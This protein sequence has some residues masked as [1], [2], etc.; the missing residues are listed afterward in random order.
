[1]T[2][3]SPSPEARELSLVGKVEMRI[4]LA[5][6]DLKLQTILGTFLPP[7][8]L[9]LASEHVAVRNKVISICQHINTRIKPESIKLPVAALMEQ[10]KANPHTP[11]IRHFDLIYIQNGIRRLSASESAVLFPSILQGIA[12]TFENSP[13]QGAQMFNF[14]LQVIAY[15]PLP[16]RGSEED[17][18]LR[19]SVKL[20][21]KDASFLASWFGKLILFSPVKGTNNSTLASG[22]A[23]PGLTPDEYAFFTLNK[24]DTW[25]PSSPQGLNLLEV[26]IRAAKLLASGLFNDSERFLPALFA[27]ADAA[28]SISDVGDDILKRARPN[29][30]LEDAELIG[31]LFRYYF[32]DEA[33][34][35]LVRVR[36]PLRLKILGLLEKSAISTT[37]SEEVTRVANDGITYAA[38]D[39]DSSIRPYYTSTVSVGREAT[40]LRTAVFQYINFAARHGDRKSLAIIAPR[41]VGRLR[42]YIEGQGWPR[43][44]NNEDLVSRG[45]AY[46]VIGLLAKAGPPGM[47]VEPNLDIL[48]WLFDSLAFETA[49]NSI[50]VS[51]E[52]ALSS[53]INIFSGG[54]DDKTA[55]SLELLLLDQMEQ[56]MALDQEQTQ[57]RRSTRYAAV[58]YANRCLSYQS[59]KA[60][61]IDLLAMAAGKD[62]RQ[63]VSEEGSKGL[64]P[65]WYRLLNGFNDRKPEDSEISFPAFTELVDYIFHQTSGSSAASRR[66]EPQAVVE[67]LRQKHPRVFPHALKY[68]RQVFLSEFVKIVP[69]VDWQLKFD[70]AIANDEGMRASIQGRIGELATDRSPQTAALELLL[71]A[72][73]THMMAQEEDKVIDTDI[74]N[75]FIELC[76]LSPDGLVGVV[77][78]MYGN[79]LPSIYSNKPAKRRAAAHAFGLLA[80][81]PVVQEQDRQTLSNVTDQLY[82]T[83]TTWQDAIGAALNRVH[84]A[85]TALSYYFSRIVGR[86]KES[87]SPILAKYIATITK[88]LS[89]TTD[90]FLKIASFVA[91]GELCMFQVVRPSDFG[92]GDELKVVIDGTAELAKS[93]NDGAALALGQIAMILDEPTPEASQ[94]GSLLLHV[95]DRL[96]R[97]HEVRQAEAQFSVGEAMTYMAAGWDSKVLATRK[98]VAGMTPK[99]RNRRGFLSRLVAKVLLDSQN[100][101]PSLRKASA[102]WLLCFVQFCGHLEEVQSQL[103]AFQTAFKRCLSDR[104]DLVQETG[105]RGLGLVYEKGDRRL[106]DDLVRDLIG[107][108]SDS[109]AQ[110]SGNVTSET[111]LFEPGALPTG[112]GSITTY[113]DI[114]NLASEVGDSTLVYKFMSLA[115]S[116]AIWSSRAAFGR[117]GLSDV[118]SDS[119]VDGY[120]ATNPK[121]YPKLFRYRFDPNTN[122]QRSMNDIWNALIKDTTATIDANFD[123][124]VEDLLHNILGKEWRV[125]QACCAALAD[126]ISSRPFDKYEKYLEQV[127]T[128]C[129][130]V[131]DDIKDSVRKAAASLARVMT[132]VL[133]RALEAASTASSNAS[134]MLKHV[135]PFLLSTS[136]IESSAEE[137][138]TFSLQTL[139]SIIKH[140][141]GKILRPF[142]PDLVERLLGLLSSLEPAMVNYL[143]L[144]AKNYNLTEQKI[145]DMRLASI[146]SGPL[147]EAIERCLDL[148][149]D[150][151]M[152]QL[153]PRLESAMKSAVG[154]PSKVGCSRV[155][156][157]LSTRHNAVFRPY[158]DKFLRLV[159]RYVLDRNE[160]VSSSYAVAAGYV[161]RGASDEEILRVVSFAKGL[162]FE[163][164]DD[165]AQAV[166]RRSIAAAEILHAIS[167][168]A[169][170]RFNS[171]AADIIPFVFI[172]KHDAHEQVKNPFQEIWND[173]IGGPRAVA[174]YLQEILTMAND[175]LDSA[176]W[177]VKHTAARSI[178]AATVAISTMS[179]EMEL[180]NATRLWPILEKALG[181]KTW[182]GKEVVLDA[183][184]QFVE[185]SKSYWSAHQDV[186]QAIEKIAIREAKRQNTNYRPYA[187]KCLG[188]IASARNDTHMS[189]AVIEIVSPVL[190]DLVAEEDVDKMDIDRGNDEHAQKKR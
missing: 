74:D 29:T 88:I 71:V 94:S 60:R 117:F 21:D 35:G 87:T 84:G 92:A 12:S 107:S 8:L 101:K 161:A 169:N 100:T 63:E 173:N 145:D 170:D 59:V 13:A 39:S 125:R 72:F 48:R 120:L 47:V 30:S 67:A 110:L 68:C 18:Q 147:M 187:F 1:M 16:P 127:W 2:A 185:T 5:D 90:A 130:K 76:A 146:R 99:R 32:G 106:K 52:E 188:R 174:L 122:V 108:F 171:L 83:I 37:Y 176:Q 184:A 102:L 81:H 172:A 135:L 91:I 190:V 14:L 42:D 189:S 115:S 20:T 93:G 112:D 64:S 143:H 55:D 132:G 183:F 36:V 89:T 151:T 43:P 162:Y 114:M 50:N 56:S 62:D 136:G 131:L 154:L 118:L 65:Y 49:A 7:L 111:Q 164:K 34:N 54:I 44:S 40:R 82:N 73:S 150:T 178:A 105:S 45:L 41:V 53:I 166:P 46:E 57:S 133:I 144:N 149:D 26:K 23:S 69:D 109:K 80:S 116:N 6:N 179:S 134:A 186:A 66:R 119:S 78:P 75:L 31:T 181:G 61:W 98:D 182:E 11:L 177:D 22:V 77:A 163:S 79:L 95:E 158:S 148:L 129:F 141:S 70:T 24:E 138:Q 168:H 113:K 38:N 123:A 27:S 159:Q 33:V 160:T 157:T 28:S 97:L 15:F 167:K 4:A 3:P 140:S 121:L 156:V 128:A 86:G 17:D 139:L 175:N 152:Q 104:D 124:I 10:F 58:R 85:I 126:L 96:H 9:K 180:S 165:R 51:V 19:A 142:I 103:P 137:V 153:Q 155:L 25:V